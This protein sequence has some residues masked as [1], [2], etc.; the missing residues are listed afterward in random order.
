MFFIRQK[1]DRAAPLD[2]I[3]NSCFGITLG[4]TGSIATGVSETAVTMAT[5]E[6]SSSLLLR[7]AEL[8]FSIDEHLS[9]SDIE[10][11]ELLL[12]LSDVLGV[13][14]VEYT[15]ADQLA[16]LTLNE[17]GD[18]FRDVEEF[19]SIAR[20]DE[21]KAVRVLEKEQTLGDEIIDQSIGVRH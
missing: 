17:F 3:P 4:F 20:H 11:Y 1:K 16:R 19:A 9:S 13:K 5:T 12:D 21:Q 10:S 15:L 2:D 18:G 7:D 6:M 8:T 14:D